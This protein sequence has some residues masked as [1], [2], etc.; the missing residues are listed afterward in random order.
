[1]DCYLTLIRV[2]LMNLIFDEK[3]FYVYRAWTSAFNDANVDYRL[4]VLF[5]V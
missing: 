4:P 3:D 1:M 2:I 5:F